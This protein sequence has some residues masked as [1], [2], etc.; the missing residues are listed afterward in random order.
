LLAA[1]TNATVTLEHREGCVRLSISRDDKSAK[2]HCDLSP[3][4]ARELAVR[5]LHAAQ[6]SDG[7]HLT[8]STGISRVPVKI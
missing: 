2:A 3:E 4:Q 8:L 5:L 7:E 1:A 6:D